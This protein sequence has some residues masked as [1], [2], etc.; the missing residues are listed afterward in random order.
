MV[1]STTSFLFVFLPLFLLCYALLPWR[2]LV[3]LC[4]SLVFFAWG[5]GAYVL[6]LLLTIWLNYVIG[7]RLGQ[8][9]S[10]LLLGV[11]IALNL[12]ILGYY[13]YFGF[14]VNTA[15]QLDVPQDD[16]PHLPLGISFF[17]FQSISYLIDV[18]RGDSPRARSFFDLALYIAM[19]PQ[20]IAGP[21]V[22]YGT[23]AEA[24]VQRHISLHDF[25]RG[26]LLFILGLSYKM[27][28]ANNT[29]E[30]ADAVFALA[31]GEIDTATAWTGVVAYTLQ[32]F[33]DFAGY[34]LMAIGLGRIMGFRFPQNFNY[35]YISQ[36]IT[37]FWRRWHMSLSS[38][39]RDYLYI[40]LGGNR[41]GA[42]RTYRNLFIVFFLC[43]LW[44]GAALTFVAWGIFHG[45]VLAL[46]R[47]GLMRVV[48]S[49]PRPLRHIYAL[50][51]V[52]IGWVLFRA[53]N[54]GQAGTFLHAMFFPAITDSP[55]FAELVSHENLLFA[56]LGCLFCVPFLERSILFRSVDDPVQDTK[57]SIAPLLRD[58][59]IGFILLVICTTYVMSG[60][61]NPFIYFRF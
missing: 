14:L 55:G 52:M 46:E 56:V 21:I 15:L 17:I 51:L 30:V 49:L 7:A 32:I 29:A 4:F 59:I 13:K 57:I 6:L 45:A 22:R 10:N 8:L 23:V 41:H 38:W 5:E 42:L 3:A 53:E 33:F 48:A 43:G 39:F 9:G 19:F 16:I 58:S 60:T 1:F 44:H 25:Y 47:M 2:N 20:L 50:L 37:E 61:Y 35:P 28:V 36:S 11:G 27:L 24:L 26:S 31:P 18:H 34:S 12:F 40:P 54:F